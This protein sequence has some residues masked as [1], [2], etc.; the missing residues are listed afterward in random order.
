ML[1][2]SS[3][4]RQ[5]SQSRNI[6]YTLSISPELLSRF[7][8]VKVVYDETSNKIPDNISIV[9]DILS[10][11]YNLIVLIV[12]LIQD[13]ITISTNLNTG[14]YSSIVLIAETLQDQVNINTELA[15]GILEQIIISPETSNYTDSMEISASLLSGS[16][17]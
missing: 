2:L 4:K 12:E 9:T 1:V 8:E 17:V 10:G 6:T 11:M 5:I 7:L 15:S 16:Y 3:D 14:E 13:T